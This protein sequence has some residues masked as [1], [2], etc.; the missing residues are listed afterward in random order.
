MY[1]SLSLGRTLMA[2]TAS[3]ISPRRKAVNDKFVI[4]LLAVAIIGGV[5]FF[6]DEIF[7]YLSYLRILWGV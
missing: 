1:D 6:I 5:Y 4:L 7:A 2:G 3:R